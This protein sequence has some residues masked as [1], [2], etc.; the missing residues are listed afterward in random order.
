MTSFLQIGDWV[1]GTSV[2]DE[3]IFGYIEEI[4]DDAGLVAVRVMKSDRPEA[5]GQ[6]L[7]SRKQRVKKLPVR[8]P[9][10]EGELMSLIDL[11]LATHD[12]AWFEELIGKLKQVQQN[13]LSTES[14]HPP[15]V[16]NQRWNQF[17]IR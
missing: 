14:V 12:Q 16:P 17:R 10:A 3:R 9:K 6:K 8:K 2:E 1:S 5:V 11:A 4:H 15:S 7:R 13:D